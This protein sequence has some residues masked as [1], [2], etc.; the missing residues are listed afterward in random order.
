MPLQGLGQVRPRCRLSDSKLATSTSRA[1]TPF[2]TSPR[3]GPS[4]SS[5]VRRIKTSSPTPAAHRGL[6]VAFLV[7]SK[8]TQAHSFCLALP[9]MVCTNGALHMLARGRRVLC[10]LCPIQNLLCAAPPLGTATQSLSCA[11][12][13]ALCLA[14]FE[15]ERGFIGSDFTV[16]WHL[17]IEPACR[18]SLVRL[19]CQEVLSDLQCPWCRIDRVQLSVPSAFLSRAALVRSR[20]A[21]L[22]LA[23]WP[24]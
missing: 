3:R 21:K 9:S 2:A 19:V 17:C 5:E 23:S 16:P 18:M 24:P 1:V 12:D 22:Q 4:H 13:D 6:T 14:A 20:L 7:P 11:Q 10:L 8:V 15:I